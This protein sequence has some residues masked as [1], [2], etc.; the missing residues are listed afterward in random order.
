MYM[1]VTWVF[2]LSMSSILDMTG[3]LPDKHLLSW[4]KPNPINI[5][6]LNAPPY[7]DSDLP[8]KM[9]TNL[10]DTAFLKCKV[11]NLRNRMVSWLKTDPLQI[12]SSGLYTFI[13]DPRY[14]SEYMEEENTWVLRITKVEYEDSGMFDCQVNTDPLMTY[15]VSLKVVKKDY[16]QFLN[17]APQYA[18][19]PSVKILGGY[20]H[21]VKAGSVLN[22]TCVVTTPTSYNQM[23]RW[24]H[25][26]R[27]VTPKTGVSL[28]SEN[29]PHTSVS[30]LIIH[31]VQH[32]DAGSYVC[33]AGDMGHDMAVVGIIEEVKPL[34][35]FLPHNMMIPVIV[36]LSISSLIIV[37]GIV[38]TVARNSDEA[39]SCSSRKS[40]V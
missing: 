37:L 16:R 35:S 5:L 24:L 36:L 39:D 21:L 11:I 8:Q 20:E 3:C 2:I 7:F 18:A 6:T 9:V 40:E 14:S 19:E 4:L 31:R 27:I 34:K 10:G 29:T 15:T 1:K 26:D 17:D 13:K 30:C 33:A 23:T 12:I 25:N 28:L 22:L 38:R 32:R